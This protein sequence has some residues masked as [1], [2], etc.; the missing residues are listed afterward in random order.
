MESNDYFSVESCSWDLTMNMATNVFGKLFLR[1]TSSSSS[2]MPE[3]IDHVGII[4]YNRLLEYG[5]SGVLKSSI[6]RNGEDPMPQYPGC[7]LRKREFL[8]K[9]SKKRH[10]FV[11]WLVNMKYERFRG[12]HYDMINHNCLDFCQAVCRFLGV[13]PS[14]NWEKVSNWVKANQKLAD[15]LTRGF[16]A[17]RQLRDC[18]RSASLQDPRPSHSAAATNGEGDSPDYASCTAGSAT[19]RMAPPPP[20]TRRFSIC[21]TPMR[22]GG[23]GGRFR[24][25]SMETYTHCGWMDPT[26]ICLFFPNMRAIIQE[27]RRRMKK[28]SP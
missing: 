25:A 14:P 13:P 9:T 1:S 16:R 7:K 8:G 18:Q 21:S 28:H 4:V 23:R 27:C 19:T 11:E 12:I 2:T 6:P 15:V 26:P 5:H 17:P 24:S 3:A 22:L 10:E 20:R